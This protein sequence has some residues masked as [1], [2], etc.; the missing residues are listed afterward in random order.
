MTKDPVCGT[1]VV[2]GKAL[3]LTAGGATQWFCSE[4]CRAEFASRLM[5]SPSRRPAPESSRSG[6]RLWQQG[7][8][9]SNDGNISVRLDGDRVLT[10][11]KSVSKGF[12]TPEMLVVTDLVGRKVVG[13]ARR[14]VRAEDASRGLRP[15]A[16]RR[17]RGARP[18]GHRDRLRR[19]RRA[20][21][22]RRAGRGDHDA[23]RHPDRRVRH[24]LDGRTAGGDPRLHQV[25][26]RVAARQP[27]R[28]RRRRP[29]SSPPTTGWRRSSTS[30]R[31]AWWRG[32]SA[33]STCS[34]A[35]R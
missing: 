2:P 34:R 33:A 35:R 5:T 19:G 4:R 25:A 21:H 8:V 31:S 11:P 29:T 1:F 28:A 16:R 14:L 18:S 6:R 3:S 22:P 32:C 10:T 27:R 24:A 12:M 13:R 30:P 15:A 20:A 26:R 9:A 23:R 7:F 17:R